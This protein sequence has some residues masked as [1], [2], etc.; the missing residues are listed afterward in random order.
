M[1]DEDALFKRGMASNAACEVAGRDLLRICNTA[2]GRMQHDMA[3]PGL[4]IGMVIVSP[5]NHPRPFAEVERV[6][7]L[8]EDLEWHGMTEY[9]QLKEP[10]VRFMTET[11]SHKAAAEWSVLVYSNIAP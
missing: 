8:H 3:T 1:L 5:M 10:T 7:V 4:H 2:M 9:E 11:S 6:V